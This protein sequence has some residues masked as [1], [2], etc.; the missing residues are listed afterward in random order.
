M[1]DINI[2][3]SNSLFTITL[4]IWEWTGLT[5]NGSAVPKYTGPKPNIQFQYVQQAQGTLHFEAAADQNIVLVN[6]GETMLLKGPEHEEITYLSLISYQTTPDRILL[7]G[8]CVPLP[9]EVQGALPSPI[10]F[11]QGRMTGHFQLG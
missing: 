4:D 5:V 11:S 1:A 8:S 7:R 9:Y 6:P 2:S 10:E 3:V